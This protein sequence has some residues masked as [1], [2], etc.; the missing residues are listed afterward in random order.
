MWKE[1][2]AGAKWRWIIDDLDNAFEQPDFNN[3]KL[4]QKTFTLFGYLFG[5]ILEN[6]GFKQKLKERFYAHLESTFSEENIL[7][8]I[9]E[10]A[11]ERRAYSHLEAKK[12]HF[13][14]E[15]F[16]EHVQTLKEFV[17]KRNAIVKEQ[18]SLL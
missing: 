12:W 13:G 8:I 4:A 9:D 10:L 6:A 2:K 15:E 18:M 11:D 3:I 17:R 1:R 5:G 7:K 14:L 16:D